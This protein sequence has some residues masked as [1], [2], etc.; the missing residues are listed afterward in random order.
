MCSYAIGAKPIN[1][2]AQLFQ[3]MSDH[4]MAMYWS[5]TILTYRNNNVS[6]ILTIKLSSHRSF[7]SSPLFLSYQAVGYSASLEKQDSTSS[8]IDSMCKPIAYFCARN[9]MCPDV[10]L[11]GLDIYLTYNKR[12]TIT[13]HWASRSMKHLSYYLFS[14]NVRCN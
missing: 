11:L 4:A 12:N 2:N 3:V 1:L 8:S 6:F 10:P 14:V 13:R 9:S 5:Y 7:G